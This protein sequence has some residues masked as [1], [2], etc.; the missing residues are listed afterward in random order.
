V[1]RPLPH[2]HGLNNWTTPKKAPSSSAFTNET[3][4]EPA[5]SR[6]SEAIP[7][8]QTIVYTIFKEFLLDNNIFAEAK[9]PTT[10]GVLGKVHQADVRLSLLLLG[11]LFG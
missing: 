10:I 4:A 11:T 7:S 6:F 3:L 9:C 1:I 5:L 8:R 2:K